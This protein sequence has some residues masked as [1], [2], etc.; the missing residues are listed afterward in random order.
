MLPI[1]ITYYDTSEDYLE[2]FIQF[3]FVSMFTCAFPICGLLALLNNILEL[4]GDAWKLVVIF[5]RPFAQPANGIGVWEVR[6]SVC[7]CRSCRVQ[8]LLFFHFLT[9]FLLK[10]VENPIYLCGYFCKL[11]QHIVWIKPFACSGYAQEK[12]RS[13][14]SVTCDIFRTEAIDFLCI[15]SSRFGMTLFEIE[16]FF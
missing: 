11:G 2:M 7:F 16:Y 10:N 13:F 5:R 6:P 9:L 1:S 12:P 15:V 3:G 8:L 14:A 4:R